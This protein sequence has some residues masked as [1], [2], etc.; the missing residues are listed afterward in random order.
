MT[1]ATNKRKSPRRGCAVPIDSKKG[2]YFEESQTCDIS[3]GGIGLVTKTAVPVDST[4]AV[5]I[6]LTPKSE[7]IL[8]MGTVRWVSELP[9]ASGYRVG[10]SFNDVSDTSESRL[11]NYFEK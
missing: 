1:A 3:K 11:E 7:P 10:L 2:S 9:N 8:T 5:E 6:A 4:M